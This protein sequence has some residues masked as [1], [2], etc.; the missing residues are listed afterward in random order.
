[1]PSIR[2]DAS[3]TC[4][5]FMKDGSFGRIIAGPVGS[6]KTTACIYELFRRACEQERAEDGLRYTRFAIVRQTLKQLKDT[7]LKDITDQ[8]QGIAAYKVSDS[9]VYI[10]MGDIK[11][12]WLL[13]PLDSPEDQRRLL[14]MQLTGGWLSESIEMDINLIAPL[15]GRIG[16]Y[17]S[18]KLGGA[19]WS[20]IIADTN[21]PAIGSEWHKFMENL[22]NDWAKF[23]QP[24]GLSREAENLNYLNQTS[25]TKKLPLDHPERLAR[26]R[27]YYD[28]AVRMYGED[29]DW[30]TRYV[31]AE[32]GD[33]PSGTAVFRTSF[34]GNWHVADDLTPV[35]G[36][37]LLVA[38]DFGRDPCSLICQ[39]DHKG[40]LLVLEEVVAE[41]VGLQLHVER[42]LK[43]VLSQDRYLGRTLAVVG[44]PAGTSR[45]TIYEET[46]F[47]ALKRMG[48]LAFP[49]PT[50]DIDPRIRAVDAFL[51]AQRD[52][53][54]AIIFDR[55]K[56]PTLIRAMGGGYR[57]AKT[58]SGVRKNLPD[59]NEYS[60]IADCLQ[61]ACL[62][63]HGGMIGMIGQRLAG[64]PRSNRTRVSAAAW[65]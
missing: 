32:Y 62:V 61:Y 39:Y 58:R 52:G 40:R 37:P 3:P 65:T 41:D 31:K 44:D 18:N 35:M 1:M 13:I 22:P 51:L 38:Q 4:A 5:S 59:K 2:F 27:E 21:M 7:V 14:S 34:K 55:A 28:R 17:P 9:T 25:T 56:C 45:G 48:F 63:A 15:S 36:H 29:S 12:E 42:N 11:S 43:P 19:S 64:R 54:P 53:G 26:G 10:N 23:I 33:D 20:G 46:S 60:H 24:S 57:Y 50:N 6:G 30:V 47:D 16:R 8:L 49:A